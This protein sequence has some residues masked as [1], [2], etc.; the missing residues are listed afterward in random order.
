[1]EHL[2]IA[3]STATLIRAILRDRKESTEETRAAVYDAA[4]DMFVDI[5]TEQLKAELAA[6]DTEIMISLLEAFGEVFNG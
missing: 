5:E 6:R 2:F 4:V 1:M 3:M